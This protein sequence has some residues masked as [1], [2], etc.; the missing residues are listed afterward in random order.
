M[1]TSGF[2]RYF[3]QMR[4]G[5]TLSGVIGGVAVE[6]SGEGFFETWRPRDD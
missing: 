2:R 5:F 6:E 4:G 1:G 3:L